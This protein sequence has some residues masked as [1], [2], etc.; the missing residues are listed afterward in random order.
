MADLSLH[1]SFLEGSPTVAGLHATARLA[2]SPWLVLST[3]L[4]FS[5]TPAYYAPEIEHIR[6]P[7]LGSEI[8]LCLA[9]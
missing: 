7:C 5:F 9:E 1:A 2:P 4:I 6:Q 3:L 8:L